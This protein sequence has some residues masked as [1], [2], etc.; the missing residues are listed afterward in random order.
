MDVSG[1]T[2]SAFPLETNPDPS[3]LGILNP[4]QQAES[5][6]ELRNLG[7]EPILIGRIETSCPC[8]RVEPG[9]FQIGPGEAKSLAVRFDP[10]DEPDFHGQ[11]SVIVTGYDDAGRAA[12]GTRVNLEVR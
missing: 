10:A 6:V 12:F 8:V 2:S 7:R 11:L 3:E 1:L 4:D 9:M 5:Q